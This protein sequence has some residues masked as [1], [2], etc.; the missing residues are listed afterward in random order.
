VSLAAIAEERGWGLLDTARERFR[1]K[2]AC[3]FGAA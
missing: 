2:L 3:G 1:P